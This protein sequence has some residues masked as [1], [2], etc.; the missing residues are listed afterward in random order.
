MKKI[1]L[2]AG[3]IALAATPVLAETQRNAEPV[4]GESGIEGMSTAGLI[5]SV[6]AAGILAGTIFFSGNDGDDD[7][8]SA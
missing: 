6:I 4:T 7:P 2:I 3:S 1:G 5:L 8:V